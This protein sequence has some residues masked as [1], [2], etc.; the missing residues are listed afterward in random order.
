MIYTTIHILVN[1]III[2]SNGSNTC[3]SSMISSPWLFWYMQT[4]KMEVGMGK[5][6]V[7]ITYVYI[8]IY[9]WLYVYIYIILNYWISTLY[10]VLGW[11]LVIILIRITMIV[12]VFVGRDCDLLREWPC[13]DVCRLG[14]PFLQSL[15]LKQQKGGTIWLFNIAMENPNHK[16]RFR[17]LG[18]STIFHGPWLC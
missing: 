18:K 14:L 3:F 15:C 13:W 9:T 11:L 17:S 6:T 7:W 1:S 16:W 5:S 4:V 8:Y 12:L 2:I 10:G